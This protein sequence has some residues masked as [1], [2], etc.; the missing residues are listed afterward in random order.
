MAENDLNQVQLP[1]EIIDKIEVARNNRQH[2]FSLDKNS[3]KGELS[4]AQW[5]QIFEALNDIQDVKV[6]IQDRD[7]L[8][9]LPEEFTSLTTLVIKNCKNFTKLPSSAANLYGMNI[10]NCPELK[11]IPEGILNENL[12]S[13]V[14]NDIE[15]IT[16]NLSGLTNLEFLN[17]AGCKYVTNLPGESPLLTHLNLNG[18]DQFESVPEGLLHQNLET[19]E[20]DGCTDTA[21][22]LSTL[23]GLSW[24]SLQGCKAASNLPLDAPILNTLNISGCDQITFVPERLLLENLI[25]LKMN[26]CTHTRANLSGLTRVVEL[27]LNGCKEISNLPVAPT[28]LQTLDIRGC[29]QLTELPYAPDASIYRKLKKLYFSGAVKV[30]IQLFEVLK[31]LTVSGLTYAIEIPANITSLT[32]HHCEYQTEIPDHEKLVH[33]DVQGSTNINKVGK[34]P[35]VEVVNIEGCKALTELPDGLENLRSLFAANSG[36]TKPPS[37]INKVKV[38]KFLPRWSTKPPYVKF[39]K[40]VEVEKD[41]KF[42][43]KWERLDF[44][45]CKKLSFSFQENKYLAGMWKN[46]TKNEDGSLKQGV[47][48]D[49]TLALRQNMLDLSMAG[50]RMMSEE[51]RMA[52][53]NQMGSDLD[54][55]VPQQGNPPLE[56]EDFAVSGDS[57]EAPMHRVAGLMSSQETILDRKT[58]EDDMGS[59]LDLEVPQKAST[60]NKVHSNRIG[61]RSR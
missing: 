21:V 19:L 43:P 31:T 2:G 26:G 50:L 44:S 55:E 49:G 33:L 56:Q 61:S 13:L 14:L 3:Y 41:T 52:L 9:E 28:Q 39:Y 30:K 53:G 12:A 15:H 22:N 5:D 37:S 8:E 34:L 32:M 40:E 29:D 20:M 4:K 48:L 58:L 7:D 46:S 35:K 45:G 38:N 51:G 36:L 27:E 1:Q 16:A 11:N 59:E 17:I 47:N 23:T 25:N 18:C 57:E 42:K 54:L 60:K 10:Q 6:Q 24:L